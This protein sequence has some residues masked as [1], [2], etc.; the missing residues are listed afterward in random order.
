MT[1]DGAASAQRRARPRG[2]SPRA[3]RRRG[4]GEP[5]GA[6]P[7][8][9]TAS[10]NASSG[11]TAGRT[12]A[13]TPRR[14]S[15][16]IRAS[17]STCSTAATAACSG[18]T[19]TATTST[20][21]S[22]RTTWTP[23]S[24]STSDGP[25]RSCS[26]DADSQSVLVFSQFGE[27]MPSVGRFG[28][29]GG[30]LVQPVD[31]AV[32]PR[33]EIAVADPGRASVEVFD[34]FGTHVR[35]LDRARQPR[36]GRRRL[37]QPGRN[38]LVADAAH[39]QGHRVLA[40]G[41][42]HGASD[43][44]RRGRPFRPAD[45]AIAPD[46]RSPRARRSGRPHPHGHDGLWR[47]PRPAIAPGAPGPPRA[48]SPRRVFWP[49]RFSPPLLPRLVRRGRALVRRGGGRR[50]LDLSAAE[51]RAGFDVPD[52]LVVAGSDS[53]SAWGV[54][55]LRGADY[56]ID[57]DTRTLTLFS[58]VP[59][60]THLV[61]RYTVLPL[62]LAPVYRHALADTSASLPAGFPEGPVLVQDA[63]AGRGRAA[64]ELRASRRGRQDLRDH[65]RF[66]PRSLSRAVA[67]HERLG[68]HHE[69][70]RR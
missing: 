43:R 41:R 4:H 63:G 44:G 55:L 19:S 35:S 17:T 68:E 46:G 54:P 51:A 38:I 24:P 59:D 58:A 50:V 36:R 47:L 70:R 62:G 39:E 6:H 9:P 25:A 67:P 40:G 12:R 3:D 16:S 66:G 14:T 48:S 52:V 31:V 15:R 2:G 53:L 28:A 64:A 34:E 69:R 56:S 5:Q 21:S 11:A 7:S 10:S 1:P 13:S 32:G 57:H 65:G 42:S 61:L 37:R 18:S 26:L 45:L 27:A 30:G 22:A 8:R 60:T 23:R 20:P 33:G 29:G 49:R